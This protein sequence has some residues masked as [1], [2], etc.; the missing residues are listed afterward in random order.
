MKTDNEL[1]AEFM[2]NRKVPT[3]LY[4]ND[5]CPYFYY[6]TKD[7]FVLTSEIVSREDFDIND[8]A[9]SLYNLDYSGSWDWLMPVVE[10]IE[11]LGYF[12]MI[13]KWTSVYTGSDGERIQV[14]TVE[15]K[16]KI[17]NTYKAV[18]EFIKWYNQQKS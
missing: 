6:P 8:Y 10:K 15:G 12:C 4:G 13:N 17:K 9:W 18:V 14:T 1:I 7:N 11:T 2:G 5:K 3:E 16:S